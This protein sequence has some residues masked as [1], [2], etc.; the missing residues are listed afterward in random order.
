MVNTEMSEEYKGLCSTC[1]NAL[2]CGFLDNIQKPVWQCEEYDNIIP[3]TRKTIGKRVFPQ[4]QFSIAS[5]NISSQ[6]SNKYKGLCVN[7]ENRETCKHAK[8][9]GGIWHCEDYQ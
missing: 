8:V 4:T 6:N 5:N 1:N 9:E 3:S 7:C 2:T